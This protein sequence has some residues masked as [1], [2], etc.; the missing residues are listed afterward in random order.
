MKNHVKLVSI[1][2][3]ISQ[4]NLMGSDNH[5][6]V[7]KLLQP[8]AG[9]ALNSYLILQDF[10]CMKEPREI[11]VNKFLKLRNALQ[12]DEPGYFPAFDREFIR[13]LHI[14][15]NSKETIDALVTETNLNANEAFYRGENAEIYFEQMDNE[16]SKLPLEEQLFA[17]IRMDQINF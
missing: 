11:T 7:F 3:F 6:N 2:F 5:Y 1:I 4:Q 12:K 9:A 16:I 17:A 14:S 8:A 10:K 15:S 13:L